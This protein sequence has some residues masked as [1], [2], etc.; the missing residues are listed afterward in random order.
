[1][2]KD[3]F[4]LLQVLSPGRALDSAPTEPHNNW[5]PLCSKR[6]KDGTAHKEHPAGSLLPGE[7]S[8]STAL[9]R[10]WQSQAAVEAGAVGGAARKGNTGAEE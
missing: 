10:R 8:S 2:K 9:E 6:R 7:C 1:M 5:Q 3:A 4:N